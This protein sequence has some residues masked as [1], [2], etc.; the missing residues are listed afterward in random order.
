MRSNIASIIALI[1]V[2]FSA[3]AYAQPGGT[4]MA[5][6]RI[7]QHPWPGYRPGMTRPLCRT[8][9]Y[10]G[11]PLYQ[12]LAL[13]DSW[14]STNVSL[15]NN[16][17]VSPA[18]ITTGAQITEN[19]A[20]AF[21]GVQKQPVAV[22]PAGSHTLTV[23]AKRTFETRN[24][25]INPQDTTF[26]SGVDIVVDLGACVVLSFDGFGNFS[27]PAVT[28]QFINSW[29]QVITTWTYAVPDTGIFLFFG[30][31]NGTTTSYLGDGLSS[32]GLWGVDFR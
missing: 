18:C 6:R 3:P 22:V 4:V 23:F 8:F 21:H 30:E 25:T 5:T 24:V 28:T 13:T 7:T 12:S 31:A 11:T 32:I 26:I 2:I 16:F 1:L 19:T 20:T 9:S 17:L 10:T 15:T 27:T 14:T 29:C